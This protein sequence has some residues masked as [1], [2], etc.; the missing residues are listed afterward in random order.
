MESNLLLVPR[1]QLGHAL[2]LVG[3]MSI[4]P[5]RIHCASK[6]LNLQ[7]G[8]GG[9]GWFRFPG[10]MVLVKEVSAVHKAQECCTWQPEQTCQLMM[11]ED[12]MVWNGTVNISFKRN[13]Y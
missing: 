5:L 8:E 6:Y 10:T 1:S 9:I 11:K 13:G 4:S 3:Q 7:R 12:A 2:S